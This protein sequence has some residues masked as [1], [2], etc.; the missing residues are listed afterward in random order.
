[1]PSA[2]TEQPLHVLTRGKCSLASGQHCYTVCLPSTMPSINQPAFV[3]LTQ[4]I[5]NNKDT[6][7]IT[8]GHR[9]S[10]R[11]QKPP[12]TCQKSTIEVFIRRREKETGIVCLGYILYLPNMNLLPPRCLISKRISCTYYHAIYTISSQALWKRNSHYT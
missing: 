11:L 1:M 4:A 8:Q 6:P 9:E 10:R 2:A 7:A 5:Y 12:A 3:G